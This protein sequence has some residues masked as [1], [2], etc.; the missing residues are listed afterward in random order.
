MV[1]IQ[2]LTWEH[3]YAKGA[4]IKKKRERKKEIRKKKEEKKTNQKEA[5]GK[6]P[7]QCKKMLMSDILVG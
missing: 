6:G 5:I 4:A 1:Q 7:C 2:S 3:P